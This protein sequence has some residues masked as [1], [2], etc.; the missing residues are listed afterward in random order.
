MWRDISSSPIEST[1][2]G[3]WK[4]Y[5]AYQSDVELRVIDV[6]RQQINNR[7]TQWKNGSKEVDI[8]F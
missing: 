1:E 6:L 7:S 8:P 4:E 3:E 2:I 5:A